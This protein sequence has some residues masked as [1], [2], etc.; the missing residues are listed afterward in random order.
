[1]KLNF[2]FNVTK[3]IQLIYIYTYIYINFGLKSQDKTSSILW[4]SGDI[5]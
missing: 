3:Y 4:V 5:G 2:M 1:M